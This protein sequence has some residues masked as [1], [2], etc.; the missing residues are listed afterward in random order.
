MA[1]SSKE[2]HSLTVREVEM[3]VAILLRN[4]EYK[5]LGYKGE[6]TRW[7]DLEGHED[8]DGAVQDWLDGVENTVYYLEDEMDCWEGEVDY[9]DGWN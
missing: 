8:Q 7:P 3:D 1:V 9:C 4:G 6:H 5:W 2:S